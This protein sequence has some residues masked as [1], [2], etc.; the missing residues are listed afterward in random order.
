MRIVF[1]VYNTGDYSMTELGLELQSR[2]YFSGLKITNVKNEISH[3]LKNPIYLGI[4]TNNNIYPQIIDQE[5]WD[6]CTK[7]R[8][9]KRCK[10]EKKNQYLLTPLIHC[11]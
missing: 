11:S 7:W 10:P 8:E 2:G 9:E 5:T 4:R 6:R 3:M 1:D